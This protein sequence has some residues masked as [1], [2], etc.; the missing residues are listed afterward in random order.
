MK[1]RRRSQT[2]AG[3]VVAE[4]KRRMHSSRA[5]QRSNDGEALPVNKS[6]EAPRKVMVCDG[7]REDFFQLT[8]KPKSCVS[9]MVVCRSW[10][11]AEQEGPTMSQSSR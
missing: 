4:K 9:W 8:M 2:L 11:V 6:R 1:P 10:R 7:T 3:S 5:T